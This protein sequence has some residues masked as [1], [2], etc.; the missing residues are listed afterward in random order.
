MN[1]SKITVVNITRYVAAVE[2][3]HKALVG[4]QATMNG[5]VAALFVANGKRVKNTAELLTGKGIGGRDA[6]KYARAAMREA[7][8]VEAD[9]QVSEDEANRVRLA[10]DAAMAVRKANGSTGKAVT[11][12]LKSANLTG[13]KAKVRNAVVAAVKANDGNPITGDAVAQLVESLKRDAVVAPVK[14]DAKDGESHSLPA[15]SDVRTLAQK[16]DVAVTLAGDVVAA[17][18]RGDLKADSVEVTNLIGLYALLET[19]FGPK[20]AQ[21]AD[22]PKP[23][24]VGARKAA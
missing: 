4:A 16:V 2:T 12:A 5:A 11:N 8:L 6:L 22:L 9:L 21:V 20:A 1:A 13:D 23:R 7:G 24:K 3:A 18:G 10:V 19:T 14:R 15:V 17:Y